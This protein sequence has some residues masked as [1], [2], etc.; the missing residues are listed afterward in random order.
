MPLEFR[1]R[2]ALF[3]FISF[4]VLAAVF[5]QCA[6][7]QDRTAPAVVRA[8][9]EA[10]LSAALSGVIAKR[11]FEEGAAFAAGDVLI[12]L[13]CAIPEAEAQAALAGQNSAEAQYQ[14]LAALAERGGTGRTEVAIAKADAAAARARARAA[15][16]RLAGC[17]VIA[18]FDGYVS[19]YAVNRHEYVQASEP[20]V[21]VL[22][23]A[24]PEID[25]IAPADWLR[26]IKPG[27]TGRLRLDATGR[28]YAVTV[29]GIGASVDPVSRTVKLT[30]GLTEAAPDILPGMSG[31]VGFDG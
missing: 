19:E 17:T 3:S 25:V 26:W 21:S 8:E 1:A 24:R 28:D 29:T 14:A 16:L 4:G 9:A 15:E 27:S 23:S 30:A 12:A 7:A 5:P 20:L 31:L 2:C 11:P 6:S 13:D 18:P 22:S 10:T